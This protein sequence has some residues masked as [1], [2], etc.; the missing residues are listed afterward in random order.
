MGRWSSRQLTL[1]RDSGNDQWEALPP[2]TRRRR[3]RHRFPAK[4]SALRLGQSPLITHNPAKHAGQ[5]FSWAGRD[6]RQL[7][8]QNRPARS[9]R[10][11][12]PP[13]APNF[14]L[15]ALLSA[16]AVLFDKELNDY[17]LAGASPN[18]SEI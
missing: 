6:G 8:R 16:V 9:A 1:A 4:I 17:S 2:T 10:T 7:Q 14:C 5:A 15:S 13:Q 11:Q 18:N 12:E 3:I